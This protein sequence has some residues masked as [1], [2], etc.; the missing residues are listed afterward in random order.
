MRSGSTLYEQ[1]GAPLGLLQRWRTWGARFA[2]VVVPT[3]DWGDWAGP[4]VWAISPTEA[5]GVTV[6]RVTLVARKGKPLKLLITGT[7][8]PAEV[9][10]GPVELEV[11]AALPFVREL[12]SPVLG[13]N[14]PSVVTVALWPEGGREL[15][16]HLQGS[17]TDLNYGAVARLEVT[18]VTELL[19][20]TVVAHRGHSRWLVAP[21]S[22]VT[23]GVLRGV[24]DDVARSFARL[25]TRGTLEGPNLP[26]TMQITETAPEPVGWRF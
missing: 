2:A 9:T 11:R 19:T 20:V 21:G 26:W 6:N 13:A 17:D 18:I 16:L 14:D 5:V 8:R 7:W 3:R 10:L 12:K 23:L 15:T 1:G 25:M 4:R 24:H 22:P